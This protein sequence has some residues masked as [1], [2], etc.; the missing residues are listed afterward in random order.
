METSKSTCGCITKLNVQEALKNCAPFD[1]SDF[2]IDLLESHVSVNSAFWKV[3]LKQNSHH[4]DLFK[5]N[6]NPNSSAKTNSESENN[7]IEIKNR[8]LS[9]K[10]QRYRVLTVLPYWFSIW[11]ILWFLRSR[12]FCPLLNQKRF[13]HLRRIKMGLN[14]IWVMSRMN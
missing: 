10:E 11:E 8:N 1:Q 12:Y 14:E 4:L 13:R 7:I 6:L 5:I 3:N 2:R 9:L